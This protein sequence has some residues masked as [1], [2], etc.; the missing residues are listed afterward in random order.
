M[1]K[2]AAVLSTIFAFFVAAPLPLTAQPATGDDKGYNN[3]YHLT[4]RTS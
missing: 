1:A 2:I 4:P 3:Y